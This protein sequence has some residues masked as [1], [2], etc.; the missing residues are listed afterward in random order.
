MIYHPLS[1]FLKIL[2]IFPSCF[3]D[4]LYIYIRFLISDPAVPCCSALRVANSSRYDL[5][6]VSNFFVFYRKKAK[7]FYI[8]S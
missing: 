6:S 2:A 8:L 1:P 7:L 3:P 5:H 4:L